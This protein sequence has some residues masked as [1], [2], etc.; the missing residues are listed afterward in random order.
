VDIDRAPAFFRAHADDPRVKLDAIHL[1]IGSPIYSAE[2]YVQAIQRA[3]ELVA[4]LR[5][6]GVEINALNIGGGFA[7]DYEEGRSPSASDYAEQIVP[8][9]ADQGLEI[10]IEPGRH[11]ACNAGVL[12]TKVLY[13]K[14]A[15]D[16][17]FAIVDAAM[18]DLLR[19]ALYE[20]QHFLYPATLRDGEQPP[21]RKIDYQPPDAQTVDIVGGVCETTDTLAANRSLPPLHRGDLLAIFSAGAYGFVMASQY[22]ARPR[23]AEVLVSGE[24]W[25]VIRRR[26]TTD[27]LIAHERGE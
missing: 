16:K 25:R 21:V 3:L 9:L 19:P 7:A 24:D 20:A 13:G 5:G 17:Q 11:I 6:D 1:H 15:A 26:E 8:L 2:P 12:L 4:Q 22:N 27:D 23:P 14:P 18:T 10:L